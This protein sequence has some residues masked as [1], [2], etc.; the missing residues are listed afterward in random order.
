MAKIGDRSGIDLIFKELDFFR[1]LPRG[2][3]FG[4]VF[5]VVRTLRSTVPSF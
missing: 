2:L 5:N 4:K 1:D 3:R